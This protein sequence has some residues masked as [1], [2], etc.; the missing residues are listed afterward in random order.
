MFSF[1]KS[2]KTKT[3]KTEDVSEEAQVP[4]SGLFSSLKQGLSRTRHG[5]TDGL[6]NVVLGAKTIDD[7]LMEQIKKQL[8]DL[9]QGKKLVLYDTIVFLQKWVIDHIL[10]HDMEWAT[11]LKKLRATASYPVKTQ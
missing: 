2:N 8:K 3:P 10:K 1:L 4:S 9:K 11:Y 7:D 6:A 5:L